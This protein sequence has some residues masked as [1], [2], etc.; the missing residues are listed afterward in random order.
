MWWLRAN[1]LIA[2]ARPT[3][4]TARALASVRA[5]SSPRLTAGLGTSSLLARLG[6]DCPRV[7]PESAG[8]LFELEANIR[9]GR[10]VCPKH[11]CRS[12]IRE[13]DYSCRATKRTEDVVQLERLD[14]DIY[15]CRGGHCPAVYRSDRGT[16]VVQG[17]IVNRSDVGQLDIPE[18]ED[19]V[20]IPLDVLL[21]AAEAI[22]S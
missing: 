11:R 6:R 19:V 7:N 10:A 17:A 9:F 15:G 12:G 2:V 5:T 13:L 16:L 18:H 20:E 14:V 3:R 21:R 1:R 8:F 22:G 4:P